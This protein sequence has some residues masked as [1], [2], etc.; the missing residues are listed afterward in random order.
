MKQQAENGVSEFQCGQRP[1]SDRSLLALPV[2]VPGS[3]RA[4]PLLH[5]F[6]NFPSIVTAAG[7]CLDSCFAKRASS[8]A[9]IFLRRYCYVARLSESIPAPYHT[10]L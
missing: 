7:A 1:N 2:G 4:A 9:E 3:A 10:Q 6:E 8:R 5:T